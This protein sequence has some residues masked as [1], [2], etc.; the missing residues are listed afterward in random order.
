MKNFFR[1][2]FGV[3][4]VLLL[5][6]CAAV[7]VELLPG[8]KML[9]TWMQANLPVLFAITGGAAGFGVFLLLGSVLSMLME[10][11]AQMDHGAIENH[12]RVLRDSFAGPKTWRASSYRLLGRGIGSQGHDEFT[13]AQLKAAFGSGAVL[14]TPLWRRR[15]CAVSGG[16]LIFLGVFGLVIVFVPLPLKLVVFAA[17]AYALA[18]IFWG[19]LRA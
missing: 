18:R 9:D 13:F 15:V 5:V 2:A 12:Q 8:L 10:G 16:M 3:A 7:L 14:R 6:F 11:G 4:V 19:L 1:M 17:V